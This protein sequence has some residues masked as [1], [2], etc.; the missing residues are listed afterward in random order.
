MGWI[1]KFLLNTH[2][3]SCITVRFYLKTRKRVS[4]LTYFLFN[5]YTNYYVIYVQ[6]LRLWTQWAYFWRSQ[7]QNVQFSA[8]ENIS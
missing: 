5:A 7:R 4:S 1:S 6:N 8:K 2:G 3:V